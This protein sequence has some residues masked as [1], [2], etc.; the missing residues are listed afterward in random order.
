MQT[1][2]NQ[3]TEKGSALRPPRKVELTLAQANGPEMDANSM[4][5]LIETIEGIGP[6]FLRSLLFNL[7]V[8]GNPKKLDGNN[9]YA[10]IQL[11]ETFADCD[12]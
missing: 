4:E 5:L 10:L 9:R 2:P 1:T 6:N 7:V 8:N 12:Q 3:P 11:Y